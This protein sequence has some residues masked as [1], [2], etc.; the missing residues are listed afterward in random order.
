MLPCLEV[1]WP[2]KQACDIVSRNSGGCRLAKQNK[3]PTLHWCKSYFGC[4][5]SRNAGHFQK[6]NTI[7]YFSMNVTLYWGLYVEN[8]CE[9]IS[10]QISWN[11]GVKGIPSLSLLFASPTC[12]FLLQTWSFPPSLMHLSSKHLYPLLIFPLFHIS[13]S[14]ALP[15]T[16][17]P[18]LILFPSPFS[19]LPSLPPSGGHALGCSLL[20]KKTSAHYLLPIPQVIMKAAFLTLQ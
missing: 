4:E 18:S 6:A 17:S 16:V 3:Y 13:F 7:Q 14:I 10:K 2:F 11:S 9:L 15:L 12:F 19:L 5:H 1:L 20:H 8:R